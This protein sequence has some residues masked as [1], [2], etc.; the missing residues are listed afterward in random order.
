[1]SSINIVTNMDG[2]VAN[3]SIDGQTVYEANNQQPQQPQGVPAITS[4]PPISAQLGD[5]AWPSATVP[6][7]GANQV[8]GASFEVL[9]GSN[10]QTLKAEGSPGNFSAASWAIFNSAGVMVATGT[11]VP[12]FN[13]FAMDIVPPLPPGQYIFAIAQNLNLPGLAFFW[14]QS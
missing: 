4:I 13:S 10:S 3:I 11:N 5:R 2:S 9:A 14:S 1:M 6:N 7:V 12:C 8:I